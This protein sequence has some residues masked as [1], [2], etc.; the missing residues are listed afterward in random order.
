MAAR[1]IDR[2]V[3]IFDF[4]VDASGVRRVERSVKRMQAG[5]NK[6]A[7]AVAIPGAA[8][9][10][11]LAG[12]TRTFFNF[13]VAQNQ[14]QATLG[15]SRE[16][17][18]GLRD[19]AK[20]LGR[21]TA[22]SA[23]QASEAQNQLAQ[24]GFN[25]N[26]VLAATPQVLAL[27]SAG[28]LEMADA[29]KLVSNQIRAFNLD[30]D[31][32]GRVSDVL[33][34]AAAKSNT[35][36]LQLG[37]ALR[38]IAPIANAAGLSIEQTAASIGV[39]RNNG[40]AAEQAGTAMRGIL[41]RLLNPTKEVS[42]ALKSIGLDPD[43]IKNEVKAGRFAEALGTIN[44]AGLDVDHAMKLFGQEA[45]AAGLVLSRSFWQM[46]DLTEQFYAASGAAQRMAD[47][48]NQ[49]LV[50]A[51][52]NLISAFEGLQIAMGE[53]GIGGVV[54][55]LARRLT[56][57]INWLT[58]GESWVKQLLA[59]VLLSG[60]GLLALGAAAKG[61]S[62]AL[63]G[64]V[65]LMRAF[66]PLLVA[67]RGAMW[68]F[69]AALL[70][71]P[72]GLVV[73]GLTAL[74][75]GIIAAI[76][77]WDEIS[78]AVE[79]AIQTFLGWLGIEDPDPFGWITRAYREVLEF[80][81]SSVNGFLSWLGVE[82]PDVF[83]WLSR[84][85]EAVK[86]V[87]NVA[88]DGFLSWLGIENPDVFGWLSRAYERTKDVLS[89]A[90]GGFL[91]WA[92]VVFVDPFGWLSRAYEAVKGV[93][94]VA[95]DGFLSWATV[96]IEDPFGW[97]ARAW[98]ALKALLVWSG[99]L[100][101]WIR[102]QVPA[103]FQWLMDAWTALI[104][105]ILAPVPGIWGW[106]TAVEDPFAP[107]RIAWNELLAVLGQPLDGFLSWLG[108]ETPDVFGWIG[109]QFQSVADGLWDLLPQSIRDLLD[110]TLVIP[111]PFTQLPALLQEAM[112]GL[113]DLVPGPVKR[114]LGLQ[115]AAETGQAIPE[116][117]GQGVAQG[118][119]SLEEPTK[120]VLERVRNLLPFSDA[121][122][123]PLSDLT[124]SGR[125]LMQTIAD[126][127]RQGASALDSALLDGLR[128][129]DLGA[130]APQVQMLGMPL[131]VGP[132][133]AAVQTLAASAPEAAGAGARSITL[134][135][136]R[137]EIQA[138]GGDPQQMAGRIYGALEDE[139][140][141]AVEVADSQVVL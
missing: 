42:D 20:L 60:P 122:E 40:F 29:A 25:T 19:Q 44:E 31:Q 79:R 119:E 50:G 84:A 70:A 135:V 36:V 41:S 47:V 69:N 116:T 14:L 18:K 92:A 34:T 38:Q 132:S 77:Y 13:E 81:G 141:R 45:G 123:G 112:E 46:K 99:D 49:G 129:P 48:Q 83:G 100:W 121:R 134:N 54:E 28:Q 136:E 88:L 97:L 110:G 23:S 89:V 7:S 72:I 71:N 114:L 93:L 22:F 61:V 10:A 109:R 27:A 11:G 2:L 62:F 108:V 43:F 80:L 86:G 127:V 104:G 58:A 24:A 98:E 6:F 39:L 75:A 91:G 32:A 17:M 87:L 102:E 106:L 64:L 57:L 105:L 125:A 9:S 3:S 30:V 56:D 111:N 65:L 133:P 94:S 55:F 130:M 117:V 103:P 12:V 85:Y 4:D 53:E 128:I 90:L 126:G 74:I 137:I 66:T 63:G 37:P 139:L 140:R 96:E 107:V 35:S 78:A 59:A 5:L 68:L 115:G 15:V 138:Q 52:R 51:V 67:V 8:L 124:A 26:Q 113:L 101:V 120:G 16:A 1:V 21:T 82:D 131:P 95:L 33:A 73:A 118:A 76:T